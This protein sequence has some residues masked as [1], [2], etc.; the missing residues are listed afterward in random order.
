[1]AVEAGEDDVLPRA[2]PAAAARRHVVEGQ[3]AALEVPAAVLAEIAVALED[4]APGEF[5]FLAEA[6]VK[7]GQYDYFRNAD[8]ELRRTQAL[9]LV[10]RLALSLLK[11]HPGQKS[12]ACKRLQAALDPDFLLEVAAIAGN[13]GKV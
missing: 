6:P 11:Q 10:R 9:A 5:H 7:D 2:R 3:L 8:I 1:M 12:I 13:S 4:V